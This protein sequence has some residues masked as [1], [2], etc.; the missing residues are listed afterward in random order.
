MTN[1]ENV[2]KHVLLVEDHKDICEVVGFNLPDYMLVC[3]RNI[4]EG[5][6]LCRHSRCHYYG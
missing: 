2:R 4:D 5:L 1:P 3:A 6:R